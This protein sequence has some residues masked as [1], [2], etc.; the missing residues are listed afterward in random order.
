M[1]LDDAI[2]ELFRKRLT[3]G[4]KAKGCTSEDF[5]GT[6]GKYR[7]AFVMHKKGAEGG[8]YIV[9]YYIECEEIHRESFHAMQ[10]VAFWTRYWVINGKLK[11]DAATDPATIP[12]AEATA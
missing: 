5:F 12:S 3:T 1:L 9:I 11:Q 6:D 2:T 10:S 7:R 4:L 8:Q